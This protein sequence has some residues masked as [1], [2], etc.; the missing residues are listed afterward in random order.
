VVAFTDDDVEVEPGW[1]GSIARCFAADP[2]TD[3]VT[4]LVLPR[5]LE[6]PAQIW[7]ERSGSKLEQRYVPVVF[8]GTGGGGLLHALRPS[9]YQVRAGTGDRFFVY[10]GKLGMGANF[11]FRVS[12]FR[13]LDGFDEA[14]G[15]GTPTGG[16]EDLLLL[17]RL[18]FAGY[19][20][21]L[22]PAVYVFHTHRRTHEELLRQLYAYGTG[23]TAMLA[24]LVRH[25]PRHVLGLLYYGIHAV[26]LVSRK[27]LGRRA[28]VTGYPADLSRV[29]FRGLLAGPRCYLASRRALRRTPVVPARPPVS[30]VSAS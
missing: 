30:S 3:C 10:R 14:L 8:S 25:D 11:S 22:D 27:F 19:R 7:F 15:A 23:Y 24:A 2:A 29:E 4:G 9:R 28:T 20:I 26:F 6:T 12:T 13:A 18:V 5:E 17:T 16:G 1:V 21:R